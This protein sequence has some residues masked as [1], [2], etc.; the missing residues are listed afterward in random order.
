MSMLFTTACGGTMSLAANAVSSSGDLIASSITGNQTFNT[1]TVTSNTDAT[2]QQGNK[3]YTV[4]NSNQN[5]WNSISGAKGTIGTDDPQVSYIA[6][7]VINVQNKANDVMTIHR[8]RGGENEIN[9][10][11]GERFNSLMNNVINIGTAT[12]AGGDFKG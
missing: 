7:N 2:V 5:G 11:P 10:S 12:E 3:S 4:T 9:G 1:V 8:L 6:G